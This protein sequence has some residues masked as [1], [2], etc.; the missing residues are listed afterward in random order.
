MMPKRSD[1]RDTAYQGFEQ[2]PIRPPSEAN[3]LLLRVTRNCPWNRCTFCPIYKGSQFS[4]RPV[5]HL[6]RDI[7]QVYEAVQRL[8]EAPQTRR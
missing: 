6:L 2:G 7:D 4:V 3:S 5:A 1:D 8:E